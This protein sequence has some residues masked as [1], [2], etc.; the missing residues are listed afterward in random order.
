MRCYNGKRGPAAPIETF[1]RFKAGFLSFED[2]H[3]FLLIFIDFYDFYRF[4]WLA[5][6]AGLSRLVGLAGLARLAG[7]SALLLG[8]VG[9]RL[10]AWSLTRS[11]LGE[12]GGFHDFDGLLGLLGLLEAVLCFLALLEGG[13]KHGV[14]HARRQDGSADI[15]IDFH[16]FS[17]ISEHECLG[18][19]KSQPAAPIE[20]FARFQAGFLSSEDFHRF[21]SI[22]IDFHCFFIDFHRC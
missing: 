17:W 4:S 16:R 12:V 10:E 14:P 18:H 1:A 20:T 8:F 9:R 11:T 13:L 5:G 7:R 15:F 6:L 3:R 2:F 22:S 21:L 19:G